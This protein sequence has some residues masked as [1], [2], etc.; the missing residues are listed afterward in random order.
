MELSLTTFILEMINFLVLVWILKRLFFAPVKRVIE[1]RKA[2][3]AKILKDAQDTKSQ[4]NQLRVQY[5]GRLREW[6]AV[7]AKS[8]GELDK[9]LS[10]E[11][12]KRLK[13]IEASLTSEREKVRAQEDR[14]AAE[15]RDRLERDAIKQSLEFASRLLRGLASPELEERIIRLALDRLHGLRETDRGMLG[16]KDRACVVRTAFELSNGQKEGIRNAIKTEVGADCGAEFL[17]DTSLLAGIRGLVWV[18]SH[19]RQPS[20]R[21]GLFLGGKVVVSA[22]SP[23]SVQKEWLRNYRFEPRIGEQGK[24]VSVGDGIVW[25]AGLPNAAIDEVLS[26]ED[27]SRALV[28]HLTEELVGAIL[29]EQTEKLTAGTLVRHSGAKLAV[30]VGDSLLSRVVDPLGRPL[31]GGAMPNSEAMGLLDVKSPPIV[32]RDFVSRPL[33]TETRSWTR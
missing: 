33:L 7:K 10:E 17:T 24:V 16:N 25:I 8:Q 22:L 13:Q 29:L 21:T 1:E 31:D 27:G 23:L 2:A 5:E 11:K 28:F 32:D 19:S 6:E 15:M 9:S 3:V 4:A 14:K 30:P 20:G 18:D 26:L 12:E